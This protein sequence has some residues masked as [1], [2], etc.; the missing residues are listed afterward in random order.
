MQLER[1]ALG[2]ADVGRLHL[3]FVAAPEVE[4]RQ[5]RAQVDGHGEPVGEGRFELVSALLVGVFG[6]EVLGR[7]AEH[8]AEGTD[9]G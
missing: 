9:D 3:A 6:G 4:A 7:A 5:P 8:R 2:L 1:D